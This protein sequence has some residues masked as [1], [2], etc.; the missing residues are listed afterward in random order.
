MEL[1]SARCRQHVL[2]LELPFYSLRIPIR[3][4]DG[5][6]NGSKHDGMLRCNLCKLQFVLSLN[7]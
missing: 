1:H 6:G 2:T 5:L 4:A 3:N 7:L